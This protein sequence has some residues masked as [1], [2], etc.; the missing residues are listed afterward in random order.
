MR[1]TGG[2]PLWV[3]RKRPHVFIPAAGV[4]EG[5]TK[6]GGSRERTYRVASLSVSLK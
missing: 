4:A 1:Q 2:E 6:A 5:C 3:V